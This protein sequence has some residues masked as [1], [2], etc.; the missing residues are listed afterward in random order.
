MNAV[1][2]ITQMITENVYS[3]LLKETLS[4]YSVEINGDEVVFDSRG[5]NIL[6]DN[7]G[8][9][10]I[11]IEVDKDT[12]LNLFSEDEIRTYLEENYS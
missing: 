3:T 2:K 6:F 12:L 9:A 1:D 8:D 7:E 11:S 4:V 5:T 10:R